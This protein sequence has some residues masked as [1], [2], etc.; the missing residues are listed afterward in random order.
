MG[1]CHANGTSQS[2]SPSAAGRSS[3]S[4][5]AQLRNTSLPAAALDG[6]QDYFT[7][8]TWCVMFD[9][10]APDHDLIQEAKCTCMHASSKKRLRL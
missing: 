5:P 7:M 2:T 3:Y 1:I 6:E 8:F 10:A 4:Q 9:V